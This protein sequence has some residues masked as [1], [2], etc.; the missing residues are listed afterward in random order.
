MNPAIVV[1]V[2]VPL[3]NEVAAV[4]ELVA[5]CWDACVKLGQ[6]F[7][8]I[9]VDDG[10]TD[11]TPET[12]EQ[13][14]RSPRFAGAL[15]V[16]KMP[17]NAGQ[18]AA[19]R[20]GLGAA[21]GQWLAVL[22]GDLQ[23]PPEVLCQLWAAACAQ[24]QLDI[25]FAVKVARHDAW[26]FVLARQAYMVLQRLAA[27]R[28]LP[29]GVGSYCMMRADLAARVTRTELVHANLAAVLQALGPRAACVHY[30]K[31]R[32]LHGPSRVGPVGLVREA[33]GSL[34]ISGALARLLGVTTVANG[35][36]SAALVGQVPAMAS[37]EMAP[38][39]A[40]AACG[41]ALASTVGSLGALAW[42][43]RAKRAAQPQ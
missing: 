33:F 32:R 28:A 29:P 27:D 35:L 20:A 5:R 2:V 26:P 4:A 11:G 22:D 12:L 19:T 39:V 42:S 13:L 10:S 6:P 21:Q 18:F 23:D 37:L 1:S 24:S 38:P 8:L 30:V 36:L 40:T 15:R 17:R 31:Q 34:L 7:E 9:L 25:V 14:R 3:Y 41:L 16:V 43:I